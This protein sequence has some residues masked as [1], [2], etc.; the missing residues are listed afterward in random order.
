MQPWRD[1]IVHYM[2]SFTCLSR[3]TVLALRLFVKAMV[4]GRGAG[5]LWPPPAPC[6]HRVRVRRSAEDQSELNSTDVH[7]F[8]HGSHVVCTQFIRPYTTCTAN[9][10][11]I[12]S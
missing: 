12:P 7:P 5:Q 11:S 6:L 3:D 4:Q 10:R 1:S 9:L 8:T 2:L